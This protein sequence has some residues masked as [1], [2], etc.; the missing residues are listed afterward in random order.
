MISDDFRFEGFDTDGWL[1]LIALFSAVDEPQSTSQPKRGTAVLVTDADGSLC[2]AFVTERGPVTAADCG[3]HS[4]PQ[5]LAERLGVSR[6]VVIEEGAIEE[7]T[8][9]A[10]QRLA[11]G[12]DYASQWLTLVEA[13][14]EVEDEGQLRM[15][16]TRSRL[17]LPSPHM[18]RRAIDLLLPDERVLVIGIWSNHELW[19]ACALQRKGGEIVRVVGPELL[20]EWAGPLGGDYRRDHRALQHAI[21]RSM[22]P[23]HVGLFASLPHVQALLRNPKPGAWARAVALREIIISPAPTYVHVAISADAARAAGKQARAFFGGLDLYGYFAPAAR[24][25]RER[26][27]RVGSATGIL[28]FNPLE[29]LASKLRRDR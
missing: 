28:G 4:D 1:N 6:V 25:A 14:R 26:V 12:T 11:L 24:F 20:R 5:A 18:L 16:P 21:A 7:I 19:T 23:L 10:A 9:R 29:A 3:D 27:A 17:P 15:W 22:G 8:E 2:A 13:V